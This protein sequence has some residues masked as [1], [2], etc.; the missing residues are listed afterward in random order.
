MKSVVL[1]SASLLLASCAP[2]RGP[3]MVASGVS[4]PPFLPEKAEKGHLFKYYQDKGQSKWLKNWAAN[5]DLTGVSWNETTACTLI[6][7]SHVVMAAHFMR[8]QSS[9]VIFHDKNGKPYE[10][11]ITGVIKLNYDIA[12]AKLNLPLPPE[13]KYYRLANAGDATV[14]K[15]AI[16][17]DQTKTL[18]VHRIRAVFGGVIQFD[19]LDGLNPTYQRNLIAGDSGHPSFIWKNGELFLLETHS[20]GGAGSGPFYGD[21][22]VQAAVRAAMAELGR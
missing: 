8:P 3:S 22:T 14:G 10:R 20:T 21:P 9:P 16:I 19:Y 1:L 6:S 5:L 17:S 18:C 12:V 13:V 11:Y 2:D 4:R 7:P 15:P